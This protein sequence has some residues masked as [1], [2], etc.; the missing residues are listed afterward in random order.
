[1]EDIH[2]DFLYCI[3]IGT[4]IFFIFTFE[5]IVSLIG[6]LF[7]SP[8]IAIP[9]HILKAIIDNYNSSKSY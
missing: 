2:K 3:I 7:L 4:I 9:Y 8:F 5:L 1:M 6:G